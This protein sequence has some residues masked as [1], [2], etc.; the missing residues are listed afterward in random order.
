MKRFNTGMI[1]NC[2][3]YFHIT[4]YNI[5]YTIWQTGFF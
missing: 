2:F 3:Y 1:A 5:E 4:M